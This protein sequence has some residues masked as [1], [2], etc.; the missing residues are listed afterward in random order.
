MHTHTCKRTYIHTSPHTHSHATRTIKNFYPL[1]KLPTSIHP[2]THP[3]PI[4]NHSH[5]LHTLSYTHT[6]SIPTHT[7]LSGQC[8]CTHSP[9][10]SLL[11][12]TQPVSSYLSSANHFLTTTLTQSLPSFPLFPPQSIPTYPV[13]FH[14]H[15]PLLISRVT[16]PSY[17]LPSVLFSSHLPMQATQGA[18]Q[19]WHRGGLAGSGVHRDRQ[20]DRVGSWAGCTS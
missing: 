20:E 13:V 4:Y 17:R 12:S 18:G 1:F 2:L 8:L 5:P 16:L 11:T 19:K 6:T 14:P 9:M 7:S 3:S 15:I 10:R